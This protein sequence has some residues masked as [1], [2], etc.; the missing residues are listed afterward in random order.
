MSV[1]SQE[2]HSKR[3]QELLSHDGGCG[4]GGVLVLVLVGTVVEQDATLKYHPWWWQEGCYNRV[5]FVSLVQDL[6]RYREREPELRA[7]LWLEE[8]RLRWEGAQEREWQKCERNQ[9]KHWPQ[10]RGCVGVNAP[11]GLSRH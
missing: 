4:D 5:G 10:Y 7:V 9:R 8:S 2:T 11:Q 3:E 1:L 6:D